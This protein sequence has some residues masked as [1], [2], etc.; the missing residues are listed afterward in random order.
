MDIKLLE[1]AQFQYGYR[2]RIDI[3]KSN[4]KSFELLRN[5]NNSQEE[6][7]YILFLRR[8]IIFSAQYAGK[9]ARM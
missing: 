8:F 4:E 5:K 7:T 9:T 3:E 1:Y 6:K 2:D